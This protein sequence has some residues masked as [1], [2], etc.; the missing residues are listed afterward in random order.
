MSE[1]NTLR[2]TFSR[3]PPRIAK[4]PMDVRGFPVPWFVLWENKGGVMVPEFRAMDQEKFR[5]AIKQR[6]C[7]VCGEP[8]GAWLAFVIGPMCAVTRTTSEP[9]SHRDCAEWSIKNCPF[10]SNPAM[11]RRETDLPADY[12]EAGGFPLKRNPGVMCLWLTRSFETFKVPNG[13]TP[14]ITVGAPHDVTWWREGR[15]ATRAEV[16]TSIDDGLPALIALAQAQGRFAVEAF[17]SQVERAKAYYPR[18][19]EETT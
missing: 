7:W 4:L 8:L 2:P 15:E 11:V 9:P 16:E 3:L 10:L 6:L 5:L 13:I 1:T 19:H 18:V 14:L 17:G 12:K